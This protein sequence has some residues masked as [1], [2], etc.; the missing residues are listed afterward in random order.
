M[1]IKKKVSIYHAV[2]T[3][4]DNMNQQNTMDIPLYTVWGLEGD[5]KIGSYY[6]YKRMI[7]VL[8]T[9]NCH[10]EL[11]CG[12]VAVLGLMIGN[13]GCNCSLQFNHWYGSWASG[14][15]GNIQID[16]NAGFIVVDPYG[17]GS[18]GNCG[19]SW[20]IQGNKIIMATNLHCQQITIEYLSYE[21]DDNNFPLINN[22]HEDALSQ[23]IEYK[24]ALRTRWFDPQ[25][26][27]AEN[28]IQ[29]LRR[30][31]NR[32]CRNA[33]AEDGD[34]SESDFRHI[35]GM[36]NNPLSGIGIALWKYNDIYWGR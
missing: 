25:Y 5:R 32:K 13:H 12:A 35:T 14:G 11:P 10:A 1:S 2:Q 29:D 8:D 15:G 3:A 4:M 17:G 7:A 28:V 21:L 16:T 23:Y 31:W 27:I 6:S 26:R 33:R 30:E 34:P 19:G 20:H 18:A 22:N 36:I 24:H 9:H